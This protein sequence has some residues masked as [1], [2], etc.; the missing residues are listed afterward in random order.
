MELNKLKNVNSA[1]STVPCSLCLGW[2]PIET[3][4]Q[5]CKVLILFENVDDGERL[6]MHYDGRAGSGDKMDTWVDVAS[7]WLYVPDYP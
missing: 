2:Q 5:D 7:H 4:P 6:T 3:L 1:L